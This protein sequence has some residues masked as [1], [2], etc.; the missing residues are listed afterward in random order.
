MSRIASIRIYMFDELPTDIQDKAIRD[1]I[2]A[3][4]VCPIPYELWKLEV[5]KRLKRLEFFETGDVFGEIE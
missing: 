4:G 5:I 3:E 2:T 1:Y